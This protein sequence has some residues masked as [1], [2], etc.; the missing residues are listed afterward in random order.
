MW[1]MVTRLDTNGLIATHTML[2]KQKRT[3]V[4]REI[5]NCAED[6]A[7]LSQVYIQV[8]YRQV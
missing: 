1:R 2:L 7:G 4:K 3:K 5:A 8:F 6:N